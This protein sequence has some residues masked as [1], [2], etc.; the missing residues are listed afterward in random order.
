[1][2]ENRVIDRYSVELEA[3]AEQA[4]SGLPVRC[5]AT[6]TDDKSTAEV[7]LTLEQTRGLL[8]FAYGDEQ[9]VVDVWLEQLK[10]HHYV[11][12]VVQFGATKVSHCMFTSTELL[13]FGFRRDDLRPWRDEQ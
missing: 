13:P 5:I 1:M 12:L 4:K 10:D 6:N 7:W 9:S 11:D 2:M 3:P 8:S